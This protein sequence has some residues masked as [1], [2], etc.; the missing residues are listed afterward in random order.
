MAKNTKTVRK[1]FD[2]RQCDDFAAYLNHMARQGWHFKEFRSKLV[3]EK[4]QPENSVYAVEIFTDGSE[5]DMQPSYK[6]FNFAEYCEAAGW[7]LIDQRVKWCVL[8]RM[9]EDAVPI[10]TDE[11]R[12]ENVKSVT[13]GDQRVL[14]PWTIHLGLLYIFLALVDPSSILFEPHSQFLLFYW[15]TMAISNLLTA[16]EHRRWCKD[17]EAR[18]EE[19][20]P[21]YFRK[22][23]SSAPLLWFLPLVLLI[24]YYLSLHIADA[25]SYW[26]ITGIFAVLLILLTY[27]PKQ[28]R[29]NTETIRVNTTVTVAVTVIYLLSLF[30]VFV[31]GEMKKTRP[32]A[33]VSISVFFPSQDQTDL[34]TYQQTTPFGTLRSWRQAIRDD[35]VIYKVYESQYEWALDMVWKQELKENSDREH[36]ADEWD[37]LDAFFTSE[38][39]YVARYEGRILILQSVPELLNQDQIDTIIAALGGE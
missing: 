38:G 32:E 9:R 21:L 15:V 4:G 18:I 10:F 20:K 12:F 30:S 37:A 7:K 19:G 24:V 22:N 23:N 2:Y 1:R 36:C 8:K 35:W 39:H 34:S 17:C 25:K 6:A 27:L 28:R 3:F 16:K 5:H 29:M 11:E 26:I 14:S 31:Y 13:Y 33:P